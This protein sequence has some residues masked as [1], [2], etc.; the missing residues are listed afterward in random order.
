MYTKIVGLGSQNAEVHILV[1]LMFYVLRK[2]HYDI[3]PDTQFSTSAKTTFPSLNL[4]SLLYA[5]TQKNE[6]EVSLKYDIAW[7]FQSVVWVVARL[8]WSVPTSVP[9]FANVTMSTWQTVNTSF[10]NDVNHLSAY[11][12]VTQFDLSSRWC[13]Y[14]LHTFNEAGSSCFQK[15]SWVNLSNNSYHAEVVPNI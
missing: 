10:G 4:F 1:V 8:Y 12:F 2:C 11:T 13:L 9:T 6:I 5:K 15:P 7:K 14:S 3:S